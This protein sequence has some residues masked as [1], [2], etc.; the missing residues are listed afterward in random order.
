MKTRIIGDVHG[1]FHAYKERIQNIDSSIQLGDFGFN[2]TWKKL[3][4]HKI[5][6]QRHKI[7]PGNHDDYNNIN[8]LYTFGKDYG[9][10]SFNDFNFFF[11][12]GA[13][14]IDQRHRTIGISWWSQEELEYKSL[15][16]AIEEYCDT[17]PEIV[18]T[19]ECPGD[20]TGISVMMFKKSWINNRTGLALQNM[21]NYHKPKLWIFGHWHRNIVMDIKETTFICLDELDYVEY[22]SEKYIEWNIIK[23]KEQIQKLYNKRYPMKW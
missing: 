10:V 4:Q 22:D 19:H 18:I 5:N 8:D 21:W 15:Q 9:N 12:R 13:W 1:K 14:S 6:H 23:I 7:I 11:L 16:M 2:D 17:K 20:Y 3:S